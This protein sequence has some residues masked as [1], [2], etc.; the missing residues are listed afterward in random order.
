MRRGA[1]VL[2]VSFDLPEL[3]AFDRSSSCGRERSSRKFSHEM[4]TPD[5]VL[6][7]MAGIGA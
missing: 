5:A 4:A 7:A 3:L 2:V 1:A 6:R